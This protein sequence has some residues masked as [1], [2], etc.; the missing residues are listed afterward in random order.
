MLTPKSWLKIIIALIA[1]ESLKTQKNA[2][3]QGVSR[4]VSN[5]LFDSFERYYLDTKP[6]TA[7]VV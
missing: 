1:C 3:K 4:N 7:A 6:D 2:D 5:G